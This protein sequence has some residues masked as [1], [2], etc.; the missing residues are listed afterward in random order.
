M[1]MQSRTDRALCLAI[2]NVIDGFLRRWETS[3]TLMVHIDDQWWLKSWCNT[4]ISL[5]L[6]LSLSLFLSL[7][8]SLSHS[9][10]L[11]LYTLIYRSLSLSDLSPL[12]PTVS[13]YLALLSFIS[14]CLSLSLSVIRTRTPW[15][16]GCLF[17]IFDVG[18]RSPCYRRVCTAA[19]R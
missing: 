11:S 6:S 19:R 17:G 7:S 14:H 16:S 5:S 13:L 9:L 8:L 12:S 2:N 1:V 18:H 4:D 10:F 3:G 15:Y